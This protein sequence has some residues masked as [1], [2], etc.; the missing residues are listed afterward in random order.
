M[1][2]SKKE[3]EK[4]YDCKLDKINK[5]WIVLD[6]NNKKILQANNLSEVVEKIEKDILLISESAEYHCCNFLQ[7]YCS[8]GMGHSEI[9]FGIG[10][11]NK[12]YIYYQNK[13]RSIIKLHTY[14]L[15]HLILKDKFLNEVRNGL[16]KKIDTYIENCPYGYINAYRSL[17]NLGNLNSD[18]ITRIFKNEIEPNETYTD[19]N[20]ILIEY[21]KSDINYNNEKVKYPQCIGK[22]CRY[23]HYPSKECCLGTSSSWTG[24]ND[25]CFAPMYLQ[26]TSMKLHEVAKWLKIIERD[27]ERNENNE[28]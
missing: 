18:D 27:N 15:Y 22:E 8:L 7:N 19:G 4:R 14:K 6:T 9:S 10:K 1:S 16:L 28:Y 11:D 25:E 12:F 17:N 26:A 21:L 13:N 24:D 3:I 5:Q 23:Y 2:L 20:Y